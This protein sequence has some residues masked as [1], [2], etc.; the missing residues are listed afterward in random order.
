MAPVG[1]MRPTFPALSVNHRFPSGPQPMF[2]SAGFGVGTANS[3]TVPVGVMRAILPLPSL[4]ASVN[5]MLPSGPA[6]M[7]LVPA[8]PGWENSVTRPLGV[9]RA[10]L[11]K[12][13]SANHRLPSGPAA[14]SFGGLAPWGNGNSVM[15][16]LLGGPGGIV[17]VVVLLA[18]GLVVVADR[19]TLVVVVL[20]PGAAFDASPGPTPAM[21]MLGSPWNCS[22]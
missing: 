15:C 10:T 6:T 14:M 8:T 18:P 9:M 7:P 22:G 1:V 5:H 20:G 19:C 11:P 12:N 2:C 16:G 3:V 13:D 4:S 17:V 21:S